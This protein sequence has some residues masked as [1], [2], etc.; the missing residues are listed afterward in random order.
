[1][2]LDK[3][4]SYFIFA[5]L[6]LPF[7][8]IFFQF[9]PNQLPEFSELWWALKNSA[10]Q[11]FF[12]ALLSVVLGFV[13]ALGLLGMSKR[14]RSISEVLA[15][16]PNF[17]PPLFILISILNI[18]D[19]FP[20]GLIGITIVHSF[21]NFGLIAVLFARQMESKIGKFAELALVEGASRWQ[22]ITQVVAPILK[23]EA[24]R[25]FLFVFAIC[26]SSF[27]IPLI[28]GGGRG[29]TLEVLVYEKIRLSSNWGEAFF[30]SAIQ[31]VAIF[32]VSYF[33]SRE[34]RVSKSNDELNFTLLKQ[35]FAWVLIY[36][37]AAIFLV[38]YLQGLFEGLQV[39]ST[40]YELREAIAWATF[41]SFVMSFFAGLLI[42]ALLL[43][44]AF[45]SENQKL[46]IFLNGFVSPSTS[47]VC[48]AFL[49]LSANDGLWPY[50]KIPIAFVTISFCTLYRMGWAE[51]NEALVQQMNV[52]RI[53]GAKE[54][55]IFLQI[56]LPQ[57]LPLAGLL[58]GLGSIWA[59]GD[60]A[61]SRI[62]AHSDLTLAMM[63]ETLLSS[64]RI[65]QASL[66][67]F[68]VIIVALVNFC[69][70]YWGSHVISRKSKI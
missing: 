7:G 60:F 46:K 68:F 41:G 57:V 34:V 55:Q 13:A 15:L 10:L 61:V 58:S 26:F 14:L 16:A 30:L 31:T 27:S 52:A 65:H 56:K 66:I 9:R 19:P 6:L 2:K 18:F 22:F 29:T 45:V 40:L 17:F 21:I 70:F 64:Y 24:I 69:I 8:I 5:F 49:I 51:E 12:S 33:S 11:S 35:P 28:V 54:W 20:N 48:F 47:L 53:L 67:S 36:I 42:L 59:A 38:G 25:Y 3:L 39:M 4:I 62:L 63:S 1:M 44:T 37:A 32:L 50:L 23:P 43:L